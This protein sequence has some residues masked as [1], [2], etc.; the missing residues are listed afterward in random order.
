MVDTGKNV[1][2]Y[3]EKCKGGPVGCLKICNETSRTTT[4]LGYLKSEAGGVEEGTKQV[5]VLLY[6]RGKR[7]FGATRSPAQQFIEEALACWRILKDLKAAV[8][9]GP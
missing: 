1:F 5:P 2:E 9:A 3:S 7:P 4:L 6:F 8:M